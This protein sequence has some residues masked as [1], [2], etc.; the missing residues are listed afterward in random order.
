MVLFLILSSQRVLLTRRSV[1]A[2]H[3]ELRKESL[4]NAKL[5]YFVNKP[6]LAART[7]NE[8][9]DDSVEKQSEHH[10]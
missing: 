6:L 1:L 9:A 4:S 5:N 3:S 2:A 8:T 10:L 7:R